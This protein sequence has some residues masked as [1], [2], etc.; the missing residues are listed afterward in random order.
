MNCIVFPGN[1]GKQ[2]EKTRHNLPFRVL[3]AFT[4]GKNP[5]WKKKFNALWTKIPAGSG[6]VL[7]L[8]PEVFMNNTGKSVQGAVSFFKIKTEDILVLH[9]D[10]E[11]P[12]G[13]F[14]L[15]KGGGSGGH[16]GLRSITQHIGSA[17]YS[18]LRLGIS[19]PRHGSVASYVLGRFSPEEEAALP[20]FILSVVEFLN[21]VPSHN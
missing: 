17:D 20:D 8:K 1:P 11:L 10:I 19:R 14:A 15:K 16:N 7:L 12:F 18:R 2:Y 6:T 9:D 5:V 4:R 13:T 21:S 3:Q